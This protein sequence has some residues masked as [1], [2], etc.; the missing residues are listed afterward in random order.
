MEIDLHFHSKV[1]LKH[2]CLLVKVTETISRCK[3]AG[4]RVKDSQLFVNV[5]SDRNMSFK[6]LPFCN[7]FQK[8]DLFPSSG[9]KSAGTDPVRSVT[10]CRPT[11][12][13]VTYMLT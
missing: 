11:C 3:Q 12:H 6:H 7:V 8:V 13:S 5:T 1:V 9:K 10:K 4:I 2:G